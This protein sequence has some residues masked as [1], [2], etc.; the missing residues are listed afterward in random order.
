MVGEKEKAAAQSGSH[1]QNAFGA[2]RT[3]SVFVEVV[4][5]NGCRTF[6]AVAAFVFVLEKIGMQSAESLPYFAVLFLENE[7]DSTGAKS[8]AKAD[9]LPRLRL[10]LPPRKE[11]I[12]AA[13]L[14]SEG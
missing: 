12:L 11:L 9:N 4:I 2:E 14:V 1:F 7:V 10:T 8:S 6:G 5:L 13:D 3:P